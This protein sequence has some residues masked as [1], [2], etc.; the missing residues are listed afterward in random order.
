KVEFKRFGYDF[1]DEFIRLLKGAD[2]QTVNGKIPFQVLGE[3][4]GSELIGIRYEQL[5][6]GALPHEKPEEAFRVISGDFV[7][8]SDGTGIVH[9]APT[10]GADDA[11]VAADAG[12]PAMLVLDD[13][14]NPVPLVDLRGRFR[15]EVSDP[16]FGLG[17]KFVKADYLTDAEKEAEF[18]KQKENLKAIIPDL[19]AYMSVD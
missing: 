6:K 14:G 3:C 1:D 4:K 12:V 10:F 8:T 11:K 2:I 18:R 5:L 19:K 9:I 13:K 17:G 16:V 15:M 7:T